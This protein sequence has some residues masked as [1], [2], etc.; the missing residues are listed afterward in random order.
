MKYKRSP[1]SY[2][3]ISCHEE[4]HRLFKFKYIDKIKIKGDETHFEKGNFYHW[5]LENYPT[6]PLDSFKWKF[7]SAK[8]QQEY[9]NTT[10]KFIS[11]EKTQEL[12]KEFKLAT[13]VEAKIGPDLK[14]FNDIKWNSLFYG[15]IDY[16]GKH[17]KPNWLNIVDWKSQDH[18]KYPQNRFQ[19]ELYGLW[20][21]LARP[22]IEGV[23]CSWGFVENKTYESFD[24]TR[25][26]DFDRIMQTFIN[27]IEKVEDDTEYERN[28]TES[29]KWCDYFQHCK[30]FN[31]K[32]NR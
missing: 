30:P 16:V 21:F 9:L 1:Y 20:V 23:T 15:Y 24:I 28:V 12:L 31:M 22:N 10:K 3:K 14:V 13:E 27:K 11:L 18:P 4:C 5:L 2:S 8:K 17:K 7:T 19:M 32:V 6:P 26:A 25:E 29:C